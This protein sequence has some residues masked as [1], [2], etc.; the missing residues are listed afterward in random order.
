MTD[1]SGNCVD[2][3]DYQPFGE[4]IAAG[5]A[6][7]STCYG[8]TDNL[9]LKFTGKERDSEL[10]NSAD[11]YGLDF[12]GARYFSGA[13]GRFT[14]PDWSATPQAIPYADLSD[15]QTLNLYAYVRNNPLALADSE[16]HVS[17]EAVCND[18][19]Q[20]DPFAKRREE[21][22]KK[23]KTQQQSPSLGQRLNS[24]AQTVGNTLEATST[25]LNDHPFLTIIPLF[26][27]QFWESGQAETELQE[28][29]E[30]AA[31]EGP[32]YVYTIVQG[33][34]TVYV[35]I[36]NDIVRRSSEWGTRLN[37]ITR[38]LTRDQAR[39]VEQALIEQYGLGTNGGQLLNKINSIA[40]SNPKYDDAIRFGRQLLQS[41]GYNVTTGK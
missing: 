31:A 30:A 1:G 17:D 25:F 24:A 40:T 11:P 16:G 29:G 23:Q 15:P 14:T 34:K 6:G 10:V 9:R 8:Q 32:N 20:C 2:R 39:G 37:E 28:A 4:E 26:A 7:R 13:Q 38:G 3:H 35:G 22:Q 41:L 5:I 27:P 18:A 33:G 21:A 36:T 19:K 12:F